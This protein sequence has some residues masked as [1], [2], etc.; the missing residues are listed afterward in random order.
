MAG[1][2]FCVNREEGKAGRFLSETEER[3]EDGRE[4]VFFEWEVTCRVDA[5]Q[6]Q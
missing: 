6:E 5:M 3:K 1:R 4:I 2:F